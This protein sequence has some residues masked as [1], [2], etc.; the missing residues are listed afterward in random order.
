MIVKN[1]LVSWSNANRG[2]FKIERKTE[3]IKNAQ[4]GKIENVAGSV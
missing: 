2:I 4:N 3:S 1:L